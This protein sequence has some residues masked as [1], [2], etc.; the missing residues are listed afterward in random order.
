MTS[1]AQ[2]SGYYSGLSGIQLPVPKYLFPEEHQGSSRLQYYST[3]FNSIEINSTFYKLPQA[4]TLDKWKSLVNDNFKFTFKFWKQVTHN[5]C[6][7]F[8]PTDVGQFLTVAN[9]IGIKKGCLL[10]QFPPSIKIQSIDQ[11]AQIVSQIRASDQGQSW[12]IAIEFRDDSWYAEEVFK[13]AGF[14]KAI[15]VIHDKGRKP[16]PSTFAF[17]DTVYVRFHGPSGNYRGTYEK[18]FLSDYASV[19]K[20]WLDDS[21][22]VYV[23]FNN[24]MG[25][26]FN[27]LIT[28]NGFLNK[29]K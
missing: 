13:L 4:T 19:I 25:D 15:L 14:Y 16:S 2:S 18:G 17:S 10:L 9:N 6:L 28:L 23:Y 21:K 1:V 7:L 29:M 20:E 24:T 12:K 22:T 26:A 3:F 11:V 5:K 27:N 8:N